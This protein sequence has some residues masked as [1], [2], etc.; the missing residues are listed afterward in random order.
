MSC[1]L[2][3]TTSCS[4]CSSQSTRTGTCVVLQYSNIVNDNTMQARFAG[5]VDVQLGATRRIF[6]FNGAVGVIC[7]YSHKFVH[8]DRSKRQRCLELALQHSTGSSYFSTRSH[9]SAGHVSHPSLLR[10]QS[11]RYHFTE[12]FVLV[13]GFLRS[14]TIQT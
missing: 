10:Y 9:R 13:A 14:I 11:S 2:C 7:S 4:Y 5:F 1:C 8:P 3:M 6:L 12:R